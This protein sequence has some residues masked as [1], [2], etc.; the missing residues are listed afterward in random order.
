MELAV[1]TGRG[2]EKIVQIAGK[3]PLLEDEDVVVYGIRAWDQIAES[4]IRVYDNK[5][6]AETGIKKAVEEGLQNFNRRNLLLWLH[7]DVDVLDPEI[8]P[9]MFPEP[10]GLTFEEAQEFLNLVRA[11]S[12]IAGM[13]IACY[14]PKLDEDGSASR[15]LVT[16]LSN[17][18]SN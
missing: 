17:V 14:H 2:P 12:R 9:L 15:R 13:S 4:D 3:Y 5:L 11:S 7:F 8:M 10:G 18:L 1:L 16:L 6:I